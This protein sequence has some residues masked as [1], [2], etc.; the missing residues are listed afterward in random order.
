MVRKEEIIMNTI[1][2]RSHNNKRTNNTCTCNIQYNTSILRNTHS[3]SPV[4]RVREIRGGDSPG[5]F[6]DV[7]ELYASYHS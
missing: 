6:L 5:L 4:Y 7:R 1:C 2:E 3:G